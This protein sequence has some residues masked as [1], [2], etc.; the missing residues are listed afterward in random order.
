MLGINR[1][2]DFCQLI[3]TLSTFCDITK[4]CL[5]PRMGQVDL[6]H[7]GSVF[8]TRMYEARRTQHQGFTNLYLFK[9]EISQPYP[10]HL[11]EADAIKY[12]IFL[13]I[14]HANEMWA[15]VDISY[16]RSMLLTTPHGWPKRHHKQN[17]SHNNHIHNHCNCVLQNYLITNLLINTWLGKNNRHFAHDY[18]GEMGPKGFIGQ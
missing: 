9:L 8:Y 11:N 3:M 5:V 17:R 10:A 15:R 14:D 2:L 18:C 12:F 6:R 4:I 16:D 13:R 1:S 7:P